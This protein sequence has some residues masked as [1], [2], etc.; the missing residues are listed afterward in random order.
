[1]RT[2]KLSEDGKLLTIT[3]DKKTWHYLVERLE[4]D[5][6]VAFPAFSLRKLLLPKTTTKGDG[7]PNLDFIQSNEIRH[8]CVDEWGARCDCED[9]V[10]RGHACKHILALRAVGLIPVFDFPP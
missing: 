1:M 10:Y 8:V 9:C 7:T 4:P 3:I 5:P 2:A 6:K